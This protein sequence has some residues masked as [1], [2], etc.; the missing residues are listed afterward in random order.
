MRVRLSVRAERDLLSI[1]RYLDGETGG[2]AAADRFY[3]DFDCV[4]D[5]IGDN[6][7][8]GRARPELR[9]DLRGHPH[10][11]FMI[12]WRIKKDTVQIVR[13]MHQKQ[14]IARA[15]TPREQR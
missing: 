9:K 5:L 15:F 11:D 7:P 14:D 13:I 6:P 1:L 8:M 10:G 2:S 3:V 12:F 4:L